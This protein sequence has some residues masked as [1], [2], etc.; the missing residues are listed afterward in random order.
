MLMRALHNIDTR[1]F[2]AS[3]GA[4]N[5]PRHLA[6]LLVANPDPLARIVELF[7]ALLAGGYAYIVVRR[8]DHHDAMQALAPRDR[9]LLLL[10]CAL[11]LGCFFT[12]ENAPYRDIYFLFILC[13]LDRLSCD[14]TRKAA[15]RRLALL[16]GAILFLMWE[17]FFH[18][19]VDQSVAGWG[20]RPAYPTVYLYLR[21]AIWWW[22]V[23]MMLALAFDAFRTTAIG[24]GLSRQS[25]CDLAPTQESV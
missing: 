5:L 20:L 4:L 11:I 10:G 22:V 17:P 13:G 9:N 14:A 19:V 21:E 25:S 24:A 18:L 8:G 6:E 1:E 3:F 7:L 23:G 16:T 2:P 15:R 12:A